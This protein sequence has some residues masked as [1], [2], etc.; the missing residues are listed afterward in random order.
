LPLG[1]FAAPS[2]KVQ[3]DVRL[4]EIVLR[5]LEKEPALRYQQAS[6]VGTAVAGCS[7]DQSDSKKNSMNTSKQKLLWAGL[8]SELRKRRVNGKRQ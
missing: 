7:S 4:D 2:K 6:Q 8:G 1:R 3:V 5:A